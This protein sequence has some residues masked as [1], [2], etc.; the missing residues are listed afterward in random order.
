MKNDLNFID[1]FQFR[2]QVHR[3]I[4]ICINILPDY[5]VNYKI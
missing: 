2:Q 5:G 1:S 4:D 3:L